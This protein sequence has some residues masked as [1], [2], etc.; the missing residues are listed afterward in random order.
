[1]EYPK[2]QTITHLSHVDCPCTN[3]LL[4]KNR[5]TKLENGKVPGWVWV[6]RAISRM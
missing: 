1:M 6:K 3:G 5:T 4:M 2:R